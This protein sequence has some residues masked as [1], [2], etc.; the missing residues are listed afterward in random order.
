[1]LE[2]IKLNAQ[3]AVEF[4]RA[5]A[6]T[7][8]PGGD[9][10]ALHASVSM[11]C[12]PIRLFAAESKI[13]MDEELVDLMTGAHMQPPYADVNPNCLRAD[14]GGRRPQAHRELR[15]PEVSRRQGWVP[16]PTPRI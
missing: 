10:E 8:P 12:R 1:M 2:R 9:D 3:C 14:A 16:R 7:G 15:D 11:T 6:H 13:D 4:K 5:S